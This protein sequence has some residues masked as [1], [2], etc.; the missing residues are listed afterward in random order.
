MV[1]LHEKHG[2]QQVWFQHMHFMETPAGTFLTDVIARLCLMLGQ[3]CCVHDSPASPEW[4][5]LLGYSE[6]L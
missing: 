1:F 4:G 5:S 6:K 2:G 3:N